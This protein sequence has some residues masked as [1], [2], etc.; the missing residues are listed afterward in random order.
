[1]WYKNN[2]Y[3]LGD[4]IQFSSQTLIKELSI[5]QKLF[6][7]RLFKNCSRIISTK[8]FH[9]CPDLFFLARNSQVTALSSKR[10]FNMKSECFLQIQ[11]SCFLNS[12][13]RLRFS[14]YYDIHWSGCKNLLFHACYVDKDNHR[15]LNTQEIGNISW[16]MR[17]KRFSR[18]RQT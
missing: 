9:T 15:I 7:V 1:M 17:R 10:A 3:E 4:I 5:S 8:I 2:H 6:W 11:D 12:G 14:R 16:S 18:S 13:K